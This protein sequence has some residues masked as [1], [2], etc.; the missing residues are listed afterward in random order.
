MSQG[1][2]GTSGEP[3]IANNDTAKEL[4]YNPGNS[5]RYGNHNIQVFLFRQIF[6]PADA[7]YDEARRIWNASFSN[8]QK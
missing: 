8:V 6:E 5:G 7:G 4:R 3:Q 2:Q 1:L